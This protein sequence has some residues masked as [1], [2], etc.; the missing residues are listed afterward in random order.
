MKARSIAIAA[1]AL[2][3]VAGGRLVLGQRAQS[4]PGRSAVPSADRAGDASVLARAGLPTGETAQEVLATSLRIHHHEWID[5]PAGTKTTDAFVVYPHRSDAAPVALIT[6]KNYGMADWLRAIAD[7]VAIEGFIAV[8]PESMSASVR[9][10]AAALPGSNGTTV[11]LGFDF[12]GGEGRI[13]AVVDSP[14]ADKRVASFEMTEHAWHST[15][16]LLTEYADVA[17]SAAEPGAQE[18]GRGR[19]EGGERGGCTGGMQEKCDPLPANFLMAATTVGNSPRRGEWVDV[20]MGATRIRTWVTYPQ[21]TG[22]APIVVVIQP[23]PGM[24]MGEP[25]T[26]GGGANWLRGIADQMAIEGF[27]ALVP[28][29]TSGLG[30]NGGNFD[31]FKY[32]DEV[33]RALRRRTQAEQIDLMRTVRDY[34][35]KLPR[36]NGKSSTIGFCFGGGMSWIAAAELA[37]LNAAVVFYGGPPNEA[38]MSRIKAPVIAFFGENDLGLAPQIAPAT[39]NMKRLGK[40]FDVHVYPKATHVFLY[41]QDLG[42]NFAA[43]QDA[44]P[45]AMTFLK[46]HTKVGS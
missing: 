5:M 26:P 44:W 16:G 6:A 1:A 30:P 17:A 25:P 41:R 23:G 3:L 43:T 46:Q 24:D 45:K 13:N 14:G 18:R 39:A 22:P 12:E 15:L 40:S 32:P 10:Y 27:I 4:M 28:D 42:E 21:G 34:G 19:G 11:T 8:V 2:V 37:G 29:F 33:A 31:S 20:P 7:Q 38:I 36:S 35:L 9:D